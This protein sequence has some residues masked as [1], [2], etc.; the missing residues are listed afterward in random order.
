M[1]SYLQFCASFL[2]S[3]IIFLL[4]LLVYL[5]IRTPFLLSGVCV[6]FGFEFHFLYRGDIP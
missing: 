6:L 3:V 1:T 4:K 2:K 5:E